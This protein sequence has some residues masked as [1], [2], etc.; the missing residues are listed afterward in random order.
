MNLHKNG[1]LLALVLGSMFVLAGCGD[2]APTCD[3]S[4]PTTWDDSDFETNAATELALRAQLQGLVSRM[5]EGEYE[6]PTATTMNDLTTLFEAGDPSLKDAMTTTYA[7]VVGEL[8]D[9]FIPTVGVT[10]D[11]TIT[12]NPSPSS[13][14]VGGRMCGP[15]PTSTSG[16]W[17]FSA[18]GIDLRQLVDKG[19]YQSALCNQAHLRAS[20][21]VTPATID[22]IAAL[23]G[24]NAMFDVAGTN[25]HVS[26]YAKRQ[27]YYGRIRGHLIAAKAYANAGASCEAEL[28]NELDGTLLDWEE[29][30]VARFVHYANAGLQLFAAGT[31]TPG[32][33]AEALHDITEGLGLVFGMKG[34]P[35]SAR[36]ITDDEIDQIMTSM[37]LPS[38]D[39]AT[40]YELLRGETQD[41]DAIEATF[42]LI[43]GIYGFTDDEMLAIKTP[44]EG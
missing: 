3:V 22:Q 21:D 31:A 4:I 39:G 7:G 44:T 5:A 6:T 40:M 36:T 15:A 35:E 43:Q 26:N 17:N 9:L 10:L 34:L 37:K 27:G 16:C 30:Q 29:S 2:D 42:D 24:A 41:L 18:G 8:F 19:S 11:P 12:W 25:V 28:R 14:D 32:E 1:A 38:L 20:G 33:N 13:T 23:F